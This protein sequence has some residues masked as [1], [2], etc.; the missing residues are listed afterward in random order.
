[1]SVNVRWWPQRASS[2]GC[3]TR[4]AI[5]M[6]VSAWVGRQ[7]E[8]LSVSLVDSVHWSTRA[9]VSFGL[10]LAGR[11]LWKAARTGVVGG[12]CRAR[13]IQEL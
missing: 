2:A 12:D 13:R 10:V 4:M 11:P 6:E 7:T 9:G 8:L 1:V 3:T 5:P